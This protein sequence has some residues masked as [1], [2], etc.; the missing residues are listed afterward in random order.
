MGNGA[1]GET[2][3]LTGLPLVPKTSASTNFATLANQLA[4]IISEFFKNNPQTMYIKF[5]K[6]FGAF[7]LMVAT[8]P[9]L[10]D[11][12]PQHPEFHRLKFNQQPLEISVE[13]VS[14]PVEREQ[15]LMYRTSIGDD[16]GMLFVYPN[17]GFLKVWMKNTLLPLDVLFLDNE[18]KIV[19]LLQNL[20][21]CTQTPCPIYGSEKPARYMLELKAAFIKNHNIKIA[22]SLALNLL[23]PP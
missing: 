20:Q 7:I 19:S 11:E 9:V 2:R 12:N 8:F 13:I 4:I 22:Q 10:P 15:G 18:G 5:G 21:P 14:T 6:H 23:A 3:T 17:P 16:Q 1:S